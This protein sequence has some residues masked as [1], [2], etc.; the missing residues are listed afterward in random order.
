MQFDDI[1]E[2]FKHVIQYSQGGLDVNVD[3]LFSQWVEAKR[4][5]I[6]IFGGKLIYEYP[7]KVSFEL[8]DKEKNIRIDNFIDDLCNKWGNEDLADF[9]AEHRGGFYSNQLEKTVKLDDGTELLKGRK[10]LKCFKYF[11][12]N[13]QILNDVQSEASRIIQE[14]KIEGRLCVSVH[15]LDFISSSE[16][17]H[18]WRSCHALDGEYRAGNL[19]YMVDRSTFMCYLRSDQEDVLPNFPKDV[20]WNSK[21][22][23]VLMFMSDDWEMLF[24]GRQYPFS[25]PTGLDFLR[26]KIFPLLHMGEWTKWTDRKIR[27]FRTE[28]YCTGLSDSYIGVGRELYKMKEL[29]INQPGSLMFNDLLSS[30][31]YDP[32]YCFKKTKLIQFWTD[33]DTSVYTYKADCRTKFH[34]GG[35]IKCLHCGKNPIELTERMFCNDCEI[36]FDDTDIDVFG[37]CDCCGR[38]FVYDEGYGVED[39]VICPNCEATE[40]FICPICS[41]RH[42]NSDQV[43]DEKAEEYICKNCYEERKGEF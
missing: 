12:H 19:S 35:A 32:L 33:D 43:Y 36:E 5:F 31:C 18:K 25:T 22:W 20:K 42:Y 13:D 41:E 3:D 39:E 24:A 29:V 17:T 34:I 7:E 11:I 15:P 38:R 30:S 14:N 9:V 16:N 8:G 23:R 6:E 40:T 4:D 37:T 1:K 21:K 26:E 28:D 27:D 10:L 2:Q